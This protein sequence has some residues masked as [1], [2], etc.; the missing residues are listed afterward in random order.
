MG[1]AEIVRYIMFKAC[2]SVSG[3]NAVGHGRH[4]EQI[5]KIHQIPATIAPARTGPASEPR[6]GLHDRRLSQV[7]GN[8]QGQYSDSSNP[9]PDAHA[10]PL[11]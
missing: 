2:L 3:T 9:G 4:S 10:R 11:P 7:C 5:T 6:K 1:A 8:S